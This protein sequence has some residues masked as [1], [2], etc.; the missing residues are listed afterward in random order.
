M[1]FRS[2]TFNMFDCQAWYARDVI[3]GKIKIPSKSEI[4][5]DIN[6][7]VADVGYIVK[8]KDE[9]YVNGKKILNNTTHEYYRFYKPKGYVCSHNK[10]AN[11]AKSQ[12]I[13]KEILAQATNN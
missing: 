8:D 1:L 3:M 13:N 9:V 12:R 4:E 5:K 11:S 7:W 6:K 10:Q 2:H